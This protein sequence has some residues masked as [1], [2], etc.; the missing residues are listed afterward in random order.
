MN[1]SNHSKSQSA[2]QSAPLA[3]RTL[4]IPPTKRPLSHS[5]TTPPISA[6]DRQGHA[7]VFAPD[8]AAPRRCVRLILRVTVSCDLLEGYMIG[9]IKTGK[10]YFGV[11][12]SFW[13]DGA[14]DDGRTDAHTLSRRPVVLEALAV[15]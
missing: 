14:G 7:T 4:T 1:L 9:D 11:A 15:L 13:N 12:T 6:E 8:V 2:R 10:T 3:Y 5:H